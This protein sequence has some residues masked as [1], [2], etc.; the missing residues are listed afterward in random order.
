MRVSVFTVGAAA[1][2]ACS[3]SS[4]TTAPPPQTGSL[5]VTVTAGGGTPGVTV[6]GPSGFQTT[7]HATQTL[8]GLALGSYTVSG[9]SVVTVNSIVSS[10]FTPSVTGSPATVAAGDTAVASVAYLQRPGSG[11][12]WVADILNGIVAQYAAQQLISTTSSPPAVV[13]AAPEGSLSA[14]AFDTAG[15]LWMAYYSTITEFTAAQLAS[16]G[17][18]APAVTLQAVGGASSNITL[19]LTFDAHGNLW[20]ARTGVSAVV[21]YAPS[22]LSVSGSPQ[23]MVTL[24]NVGLGYLTSIAFDALGDMWIIG[25]VHD[26]Y[27]LL[28][29]T[30]NQLAAGGIQS[31]AVI[32]ESASFDVP[33]ELAFDKSGDLNVP[34]K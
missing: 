7:I 31:P 1:L 25:T 14:C 15:N 6:M 16:S 19:G 21:A 28:E 30:P 32:V 11:G 9:G 26:A 20:V 2:A 33:T 22:Q 12:L 23:P 10:V 13:L 18:P 8:T 27:A 34:L 5:T 3:G 29:F 17:T 24:S 4:P